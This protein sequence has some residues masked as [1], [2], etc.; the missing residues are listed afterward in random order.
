MSAR[1]KKSYETKLEDIRFTNTHVMAMLY[2]WLYYNPNFIP[3]EGK[4]KKLCLTPMGSYA[5][6]FFSNNDNLDVNTPP[7]VRHDLYA[8]N[9]DVEKMHLMGT[10]L[11]G[12]RGNR[13][14]IYN[15][16]AEKLEYISKYPTIE[17]AKSALL[18]IAMVK[19]K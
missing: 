12:E 5:Y 4:E 18:V 19:G 1:Y 17:D 13:V 15:A 2:N 7:H 8:L 3:E 10:I 6:G 16:D 14:Y 9:A 11:E